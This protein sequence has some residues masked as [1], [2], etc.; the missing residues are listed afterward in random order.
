MPNICTTIIDVVGFKQPIK[1]FEK[2]VSNDSEM[3]PFFKDKNPVEKCCPGC[4]RNLP[5]ENRLR[6]LHDS[7]YGYP[8]PFIKKLSKKFSKLLFEFKYLET[9]AGYDGGFDILTTF[10]ILIVIF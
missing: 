1:K 6:Y 9:M 10:R 7:R 4:K 5:P 3:K 8:K 2:F